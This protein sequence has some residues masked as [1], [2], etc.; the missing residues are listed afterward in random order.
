[1]MIALPT[2]YITSDFLQSIAG[3]P[4]AEELEH[5]ATKLL[6]NNLKERSIRINRLKS[7]VKDF[8]SSD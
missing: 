2:A 5:P 4:K 6:A 3:K 8:A 1:M 7:Q